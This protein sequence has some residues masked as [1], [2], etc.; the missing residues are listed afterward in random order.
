[1]TSNSKFVSTA[2]LNLHKR[3]KSLK[4]YQ[5]HVD[6]I[7]TLAANEDTEGELNVFGNLLS[8]SDCWSC[9]SCEVKFKSVSLHLHAVFRLY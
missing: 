9:C 8:P 2:P 4:A 1:M 3:T 5:D 6:K 7:G